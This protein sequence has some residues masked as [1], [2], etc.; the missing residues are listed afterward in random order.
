MKIKER[1]WVQPEAQKSYRKLTFPNKDFGLATTWNLEEI[2]PSDEL[3]G[4]K[5]LLFHPLL[6]SSWTVSKC[7]IIINLDYNTFFILWWFKRL[8]WSLNSSRVFFFLIGSSQPLELLG[9][10]FWWWHLRIPFQFPP[11]KKVNSARWCFFASSL[12]TLTFNSVR[13]RWTWMDRLK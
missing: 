11:I 2:L 13:W 5:F 1:Q 3:V 10:D 9:D 6:S 8:G 12:A 7:S 4:A